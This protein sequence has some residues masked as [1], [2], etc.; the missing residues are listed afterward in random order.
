MGL[1][2][3]KLYN[4]LELLGFLFESL[5]IRDLR[6]YADYYDG[7]VM[8]Y[9]DFNTNNEVNAIVELNDGR[10]IAVEVKL[11]I[12]EIDKAAKKLLSIKEYFKAK[13]AKTLP[14]AL[15]IIS[16]MTTIAH[17]R[18]DGVIVLPI[19]SLKP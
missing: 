5:V 2:F 8:Y 6:T 16:G 19:T 14:S 1:S 13:G 18:D 9:K 15:V 4:D 3:E 7:K 10:W 11:G 17:K 12:Q